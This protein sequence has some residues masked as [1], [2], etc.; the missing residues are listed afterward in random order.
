MGVPRLLR[1]SEAMGLCDSFLVLTLDETHS[2]LTG[3]N[4]DVGRTINAANTA[5]AQ[6]TTQKCTQF[7]FTKG[8]PYAGTEYTSE[9][10]CGSQLATGGVKAPA[11][12]CSMAC[13]GNATQPCGGGSR[14]SLW[15]TS[16]ITAPSVN[17]GVDGWVSMGCYS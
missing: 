5:D 11:T 16:K 13:G 14:L 8:F 12:D 4:R 6:M 15:K 10:Y 1:V 7:C 17:P 3:A 2:M 9:C